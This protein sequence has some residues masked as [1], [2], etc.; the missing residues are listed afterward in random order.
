M[1]KKLSYH[2]YYT[3]AI[4]IKKNKYFKRIDLI[5]FLEKMVLK[6]DQYFVAQYQIQPFMQNIKI[7]KTN[8]KNSQYIRDNSFFIGI[9]PGFYSSRFN[10]NN[11]FFKKFINKF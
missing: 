9:H 7:K 6:Q 3:Y 5:K 4:T 8:L 1:I 11:K 10:K 2:S